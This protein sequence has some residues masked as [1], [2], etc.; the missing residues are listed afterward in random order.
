MEK[1][2]EEFKNDVSSFISN[3]SNGDKYENSIPKKEKGLQLDLYKYLLGMNYDVVYELE[4]PDLQQYLNESFDETR[5]MFTYIEGSLRPDI[6]VKLGD[7]GYTSIELKYNEPDVQEHEKDRRKNKVYIEHCTDIHYALRI[8]LHKKEITIDGDKSHS[9]ADR[10]YEYSKYYTCD[11]SIEKGE[12]K[13]ATETYSI[14]ELWA[15]KLQQINDHKGEFA[16][17]GY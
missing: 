16:K 7:A 6:V 14:K 5:K 17:Y 4:L 8:H 13:K 10:K 9:C 2:L 15:D 3:V 1:S 12:Y 11:E